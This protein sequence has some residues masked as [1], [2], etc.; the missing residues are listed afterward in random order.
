MTDIKTQ[1]QRFLNPFPDIEKLKR[2]LL[3]TL[4]KCLVTGK[5]LKG[6]IALSRTIKRN[7]LRNTN[8]YSCV[9]TIGKYWLKLIKS[10]SVVK[11]A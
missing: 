1:K 3:N 5:I 2:N 6:A 9:K 11:I 7:K 4:S 10:L 8:C